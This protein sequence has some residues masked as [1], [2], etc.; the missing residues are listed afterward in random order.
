MPVSKTKKKHG[1]SWK[2]SDRGPRVLTLPSGE[3]CLVR[4]KVAISDLVTEGIIDSLDA[5]TGT[6]VGKT[7]PKAQGRPSKVNSEEVMKDPKKFKALMRTV[8]KIVCYAVIDPEV[9]P[10]S[11]PATASNGE[12]LLDDENLPV[13]R[14]LAE[15]ERDAEAIYVDYIAENDRFAIMETVTS[16]MKAFATF[17]GESEEA[18]GDLSA[19]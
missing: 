11:V 2:G 14:E 7:I 3:T 6:V 10:S 19:S 16:G 8:D 9:L 18:V 12:P 1:S 13:F 15:E 17:R 5:L 4:S